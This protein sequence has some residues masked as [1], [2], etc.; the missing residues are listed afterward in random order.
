QRALATLASIAHDN[1]DLQVESCLDQ[2][3]GGKLPPELHLDALEAARR[4]DT[5]HLREKIAQYEAAL[6]P[7]DPVARYRWAL[8]GGS[9]ERGQFVFFNKTETQ[10]QRCHK[11]GDRGSGNTGPDLSDIGHSK[12]RQYL[13]ESIVTPNRTMAEGYRYAAL[14][15]D[16]G[17]QLSGRIL[18]E[19][20]AAVHL[21]VEENKE[22]VIPKDTIEH[23]KVGLSAMPANLVEKLTPRELRNLVAFLAAQKKDKP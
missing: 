7:S 2:L 6:D 5:P 10:C 4:R 11:V 15:T 16:D 23:R 22:I 17:K 1:A 20:P 8:E 14:L 3:L 12:R 18:E 13:L 9:E 19:T 21:E